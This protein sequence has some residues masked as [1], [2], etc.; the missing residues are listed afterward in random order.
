LSGPW[1]NATRRYASS[2]PPAT[3]WPP[4]SGRRW[5]PRTRAP[6]SGLPCGM[7][8]PRCGPSASP[9]TE[10]RQKWQRQCRG[11]PRELDP[12][13]PRRVRKGA[14][15]DRAVGPWAWA[16]GPACRRPGSQQAVDPAAPHGLGRD[17][18]LARQSSNAIRLRC[19]AGFAAACSWLTC[20][21][22]SGVAVGQWVAASTMVVSVAPHTPHTSSNTPTAALT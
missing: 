10:R 5:P 21:A 3:R 2:R 12:R 22:C 7:R 13:S 4:F 18:P 1:P 11:R 6:G 20:H 9:S 14:H 15:S 8:W 17:C 19:S 16:L